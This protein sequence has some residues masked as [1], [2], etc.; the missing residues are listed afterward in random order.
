[1]VWGA[2][3][4]FSCW[5]VSYWVTQVELCFS[6]EISDFSQKSEPKFLTLLLNIF[7]LAGAHCIFDRI[8]AYP[9]A[10]QGVGGYGRC[11][12]LDEEGKS[13]REAAVNAKNAAAGLTDVSP[14]ASI[15]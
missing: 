11:A 3:P 10:G 6:A 13:N 4:S 7:I 8:S 2:L 1:M 15:S 12:K 9:R 14:P 5:G